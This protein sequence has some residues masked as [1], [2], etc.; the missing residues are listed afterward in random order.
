MR[1]VDEFYLY[2]DSLYPFC[3]GVVGVNKDYIQEMGRYMNIDKNV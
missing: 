2:G 1:E 3:I